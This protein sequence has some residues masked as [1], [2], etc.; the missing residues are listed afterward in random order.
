MTWHERPLESNT[1]SPKLLNILSLV[2]PHPVRLH[3]D[4][5]SETSSFGSKLIKHADLRIEPRNK[6]EIGLETP[7]RQTAL[8]ED[9]MDPY[10]PPA[11]SNYRDLDS[12][13]LLVAR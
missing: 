11:T 9:Q 13:I 2:L 4:P 6:A 1:I 10:I 5:G 8:L 7:T 3:Y 12:D